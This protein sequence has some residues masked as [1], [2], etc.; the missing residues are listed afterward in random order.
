MAGISSFADG[1]NSKT[2]KVAL[3]VVLLV[4]A[5]VVYF[6]R[7]RGEGQVD[8]ADS[9]ILYVCPADAATLSVT[10]AGYE[11]M[12]RSGQAGP[13]EG[14]TGRTRGTFLKCPKCGKRTM[15]VASRCPKD[16]AVF[17]RIAE[18]GSLAGCPKCKWK[19][20]EEQR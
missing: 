15:V 17:A 9:G 5:G 20:L 7:T 6:L 14:A 18:D 3:V 19:P 11:E 8:T 1:S 16:G 12:L 4:A 2:I 10:P 13:P